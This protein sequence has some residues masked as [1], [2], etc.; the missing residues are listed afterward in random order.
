MLPLLRCA[1]EYG[2]HN[3]IVLN[4]LS[5]WSLR[6]LVIAFEIVDSLLHQE[7]SKTS[8]CDGI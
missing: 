7:M 3:K 2:I 4:T 6:S 8:F 5:M 1:V